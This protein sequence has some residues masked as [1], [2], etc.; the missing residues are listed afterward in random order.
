MYK[1]ED[2]NIDYN[3]ETTE[4]NIL[5][6]IKD[7]TYSYLCNQLD[8]N[9]ISVEYLE[10]AD[11]FLGRKYD[12]VDKIREQLK[13]KFYNAPFREISERLDRITLNGNL[14]KTDEVNILSL[15]KEISYVL[16]DLAVHQGVINKI[17]QDKYI[18]NQN[19]S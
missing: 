4:D 18:F 11:N 7:I 14:A 1:Y 8:F 10:K 9:E 19:L 15:T 12:D 2:L 3:K 5:R 16:D 6:D 13:C 17:I